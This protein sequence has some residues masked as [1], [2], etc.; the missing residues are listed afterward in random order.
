M[1]FLGKAK[2]VMTLGRS[3]T[4]A[5]TTPED[6]G[7]CKIGNYIIEYYRMGWNV[8]LKAATSRQ[9]TTVL[10]DLIEGSEYKFRVKAESP[11]GISDPSEES[12]VI[13]IPDPKRGITSPPPRTTSSILE[14]QEILP[15][16]SKR[17]KPR[18]QSSTRLEVENLPPTRPARTKVKSSPTT[19][20]T[21]PLF[22]RKEPK[23][24]LNKQI[25]DRSSVARDLAYGSP[26]LKINKKEDLISNVEDKS[27]NRNSL[28]EIKKESLENRPTIRILENQQ[29]R[30]INPS[31]KVPQIINDSIFTN[32]KSSGHVDN[33]FSSL[34]SP[35]PIEIHPEKKS[36]KSPREDNQDNFG[37]N[38]FMLV[39]MPN[40]SKGK[41]GHL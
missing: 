32:P 16:A 11:Y 15:T 21:T 3:V 12:D 9:L 8:W 13:F 24:E 27:K 33:T 5:W 20:E 4:L 7:G 22:I 41:F 37:S 17:T 29:K 25:F 26:D 10:G 31:K 23:T 2:V 30:S 38:E 6:D 14:P 19:P 18:S 34:R 36:L 28:G 35:S 39:L 1:W 40:S